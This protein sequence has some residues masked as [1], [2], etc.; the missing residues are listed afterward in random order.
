MAKSF[1]IWLESLILIAVVV[2]LCV[3][4]VDR[5]V[6]LW[7]HEAFGGRQI[8]TAL[9]ESPASSISLI[10]AALFA[11]CGLLALFG[12]RFSRAET[13]IAMSSV[14]ALSTI[15]IKDQLKVIFGRTW[16][17]SW[18]PGIQSFLRN[19]AYGFHF[20][21]SGKSFES[22]PSG[23]AAFAAAI[24]SVFWI[25]CPKLRVLC[26]LGII[27]VDVG[28]VALDLH[29]VSDV[30]AGSFLGAS[31]GLFTVSLWHATSSTLANGKSE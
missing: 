18:A 17:D 5:P 15:L 20:F 12:R 7:I 30:I 19:G 22:F 11:A 28:L 4:W 23:H 26:G 10:S 21:Q 31:I 9:T 16:P 24:L 29:F 25:L 6:A 27:A 13:T 14:S 2:W 8:P 3:V 1:T